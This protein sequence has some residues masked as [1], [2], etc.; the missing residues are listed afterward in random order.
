MTVDEIKAARKFYSDRRRAL[1]TWAHP[2]AIWTWGGWNG[3]EV[4]VQPPAAAP[5][6]DSEDDDDAAGASEDEDTQAHS[7]AQRSGGNPHALMPQV[8]LPPLQ[9]P[10]P[11]PP[12]VPMDIDDM[13]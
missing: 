12:A 5:D 8:Q 4:V 6:T 10:P 2:P 1:H 13:N 9:L 7:L 11:L 3:A